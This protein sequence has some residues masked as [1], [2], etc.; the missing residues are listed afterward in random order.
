MEKDLQKLC[1]NYARAKG[2]FCYAINPP[3]FKHMTYGTLMQMPDLYIVDFNAYFELK[4]YK[5]T[6]AHKERQE[7]QAKRRRE[8]VQHGAKAYKVNTLE[9]FIK[10]L[11]FLDGK[12]KSTSK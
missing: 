4:D 5:Y 8:L 11:E 12:E 9:N 2:Y 10:I 1:V 3:N 7:K 6:K